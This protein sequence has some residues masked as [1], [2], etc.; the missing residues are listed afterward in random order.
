MARNSLRALLAVSVLW[1]TFASI[2]LAI[3]L[4]RKVSA[5]RYAAFGLFGL[6]LLK[7]YLMDVWELREV[8]RILSLVIL[9][10]LL[11]VASYA[12]SRLRSRIAAAL[13][14]AAAVAHSRRH[15]RR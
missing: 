8:Y 4:G 5:C 9:G 10:A 12:Y 11:V 14:W 15:I 7:V 13:V 1:T 6:T 2:M 3:G